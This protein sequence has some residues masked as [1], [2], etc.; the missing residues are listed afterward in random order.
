MLGKSKERPS[1]KREAIP[2]V[3]GGEMVRRDTFVP[4]PYYPSF[5]CEDCGSWSDGVVF[6]PS[7]EFEKTGEYER[8]RKRKKEQLKSLT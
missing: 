5:V 2:C 7:E 6:H 1:S 4:D 8:W 3:C